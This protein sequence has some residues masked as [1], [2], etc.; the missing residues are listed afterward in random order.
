M[1]R[2]CVSTLVAI[3]SL[4]GARADATP[5][6]ACS[7]NGEL[8]NGRCQ[9]DPQWKGDDCER[10]NLL[11]AQA[12]AGLQ[13]KGNFSSW[14]GSV[15]R[16]EV[17]GVYHMFAAVMQH[18]CGLN[19]WRPNSAIGHATS[20]SHP[21]GPYALESLIM[22]HFAHSPQ[23]VRDI[24][25]TWLVYHVGAG[26][27]NTAPC[28]NQSSPLCQYATNC[29]GGCTG[30]EHPWLSGENF[31]GPAGVLK[32]NS[33]TGPWTSHVIGACDSVPGCM[34]NS[35][36]P[37]NGN[38]MN[39]APYINSDGSVSMLWRSI[40]YTGGGKSQSYY[41]LASAPNSEGPFTWSTDNI[42][43][44]FSSCHI[45]DGFMYKNR[46]GWHALFHS[47]CEQT[48]GGAAGG[49]AYSTDG[50]QWTFH[51]KNAYDNNVTLADG[52][53]WTV[54][55]RERPKLIIENGE[56]THLINGVSLPGP[57]NGCKGGDHSFTF[58]QPINGRGRDVE[59][60]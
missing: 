4:H 25:G 46:R 37:G 54:Q 10:L 52:G 9:C 36:Y 39:P 23:A 24:D 31:Y 55:Q 51:P 21:A 15:Q 35:T 3:L 33:P 44:A 5:T 56:I 20:P 43:P 40:N 41:A 7:L 18:G 60:I 48:S 6:L 49:H 59:Y 53:K 13:A 16:D 12:D 32:A 45:E 8:V 50:V 42:F 22:P 11:P 34:P 1:E 38:D 30:P 14:G 19:A 29:S 26:S 27:N 28:S 47:D 57:A 58:I 2:Y 17:T